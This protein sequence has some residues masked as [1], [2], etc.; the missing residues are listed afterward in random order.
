[1]KKQE[2]RESFNKYDAVRQNTS[3][4]FKKGMMSHS[5]VNRMFAVIITCNNQSESYIHDFDKDQD[6]FL[7]LEEVIQLL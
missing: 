2:L 3:S 1:M 4:Q 7:T 5:E 6:G